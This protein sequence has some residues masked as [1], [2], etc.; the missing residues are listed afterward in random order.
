MQKE[1]R[2]IKLT[3]KIDKALEDQ[4]VYESDLCNKM[5]ELR[6]HLRISHDR[7]AFQALSRLV[8]IQADMDDLNDLKEEVSE[9]NCVALMKDGDEKEI[10][11]LKIVQS[12]KDE[13]ILGLGLSGKIKQLDDQKQRFE[14]AGRTNTP[15]AMEVSAAIIRLLQIQDDISKLKVL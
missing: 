1:D 8:A 5:N 11:R 3:A 2:I 10:L 7:E 15:K 14:T 12:L 4:D 6:D 13:D 9:I